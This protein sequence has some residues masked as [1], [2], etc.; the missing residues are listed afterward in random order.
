MEDPVTR[1]PDPVNKNIAASFACGYQDAEY[2]R[3]SLQRIGAGEFL[4]S[5]WIP[6]IDPALCRQQIVEPT[7]PVE[8]K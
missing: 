1:Y 2:F 6:G 7:P 5:A 8:T 3:T 4:E